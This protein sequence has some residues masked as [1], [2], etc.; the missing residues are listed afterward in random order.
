[1]I[2]NWYSYKNN[3]YGGIK[4][5][6]RRNECKICR[7]KCKKEAHDKASLENYIEEVAEY[8]SACAE[9]SLLTAEEAKLA[10]LEAVSAQKEYDEK[11]GDAE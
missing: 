11:Y 7:I 5:E 1:M 6:Q 4:N 9:L 10:A 3:N 2:Y 8:A